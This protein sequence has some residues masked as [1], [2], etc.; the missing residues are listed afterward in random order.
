MEPKGQAPPPTYVGTGQPPPPY[1]A[2]QQGPAAYPPPGAVSYT[3]HPQVT[4]TTVHVGPQPTVVIGGV[5]CCP[6][7]HS[8]QW[9]ESYDVCLLLFIILGVI[10]F[11]PIGLL[12]LLCI[13]SAQR[14]VCSNCG[15]QM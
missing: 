3:V 6:H 2:Q 14:R 15:H 1:Y 10:L 9:T 4:T 7:C 5:P 12:Y 13:V 8:T 11:F